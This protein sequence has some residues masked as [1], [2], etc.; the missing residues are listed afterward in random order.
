MGLTG[1]HEGVDTTAITDMS[2]F[3]QRKINYQIPPNYPFVGAEFNTTRAGIHADGLTKNE[4]IYNIFDT[5][6]YLKRPCKVSI[7]NASGLAGIAFWIHSNIKGGCE[8]RKDHPGILAIKNWIDEEYRLGR[9]TTISESE[10]LS[11]S[12]KHLPELF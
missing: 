4:E 7:T 1:I 6:K 12:E 3:F 10:M 11:L 5:E 2:E 8:I 9:T